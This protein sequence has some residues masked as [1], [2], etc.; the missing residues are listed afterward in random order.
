[1]HVMN[2]SSIRLVE[3]FLSR[4]QLNSETNSS[5]CVV[6]GPTNTSSY[7]SL[8]LTQG[9]AVPSSAT[10][11]CA[12]R[13]S[14]QWKLELCNASDCDHLCIASRGNG[15]LCKKVVKKKKR[16]ERNR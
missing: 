11:T 3:Q 2:K 10:H 13:K 12:V 16:K 9:P 1:M 4:M 14:D 5:R 15:C 7:S 8:P 6:I